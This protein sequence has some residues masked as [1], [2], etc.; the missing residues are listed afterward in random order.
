MSQEAHHHEH[1]H[2]DHDHA[3]D[4]HRHHERHGHSHG[5]VDPA[6]ATSE[7]GLRAVKWSFLLLFATAL[8]QLAI[9][10]LSGSVALLA[11]TIHNFGDAATAIPLGVAFAVGRRKA[12]KRFSY[13]FGRV[14]DLAGLAVVGVIFTS[15]VVAAYEAVERLLHPRPLEYLGAVA[16]ASV[17]G[18]LGNEA[19]AV[20]RIRAGRK[21]G[22]AALVADGYHARTD[23]WTSLAVLLGALGAWLGYPIADPMVGLGITAAISLIVW[24]SAGEVLLRTLDGIEP[25]IIEAIESSARSV[26]GVRDVTQVR[27]RWIGHRRHAEVNITVEPSMSVSDAHHLAVEVH[28]ETRANVPFL[29]EVVVHVD[30]LDESGESYHG[31]K[32]SPPVSSAGETRSRDG[33]AQDSV[34]PA[35]EN[36]RRRM[37]GALALTLAFFGVE[38]VGGLL[39]ASLALLADAAHMFT[40]VGALIL[41]FAAMTVAESIPTKRYTFGFHRF[42][43]LAA[44]VN[45]EVLLVV[46]GFIFYEA[47]RR[48]LEPPEIQTGIMMWVAVAGLAA[49]LVSMKILHGDHQESLNVKAAYLEVLT[50]ALGSIGVIVA[51]LVMMPTGWYWLDPIISA[52]IGLLVLPRTISLL[53]QSAHILLEGAPSEVDVSN[54]RVRLL[55]IPGVE[56]IHDLHVWTLTSGIH[57]ASVHVRAAADSPRGQVLAAVRQVLREALGV[58]H[59]TVQVEWGATVTCEM[60]G[61]HA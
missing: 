43:I 2:D 23:G 19:V 8:V 15:A 31:S 45:A 38:V 20:L 54:A 49:N 34:A 51:A 12:T 56:E 32:H 33:E 16:A 39:S 17:L 5:I 55:A 18:F 42:E 58:E 41:A 1:P 26:A 47:Y 24:R 10:F 6:I 46:S 60:T 3:P 30:P 40:D 59:A 25:G 27:A 61:S 13:G 44:F 57:S 14:E 52:G 9:V 50:D 35:R 11:D 22:S 48:L 53:K 7:Q 4:A 36:R 28:G 21:I 37:L 29:S